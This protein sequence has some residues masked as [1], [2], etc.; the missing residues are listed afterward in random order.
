M[1][2]RSRKFRLG[3]FVAMMFIAESAFATD[4]SIHECLE[5]TESSLALNS[6]HQLLAERAALLV[7]AAE[8]CPT[9]IRKECLRRTEANN[10]AIPTI[11]FEYKDAA[12]QDLSDVRVTV[13]GKPLTETLTGTPL[14]VDPGAHVFQFLVPNQPVIERKFVLSTG[15]KNRRE[16]IRAVPPSGSVTAVETDSKPRSHGSSGLG[17]QRIAALITGGIGVAGVAVGSIF[18]GLAMSR[19]TKAEAACPESTCVNEADSKKWD[20]AYSAGNVSTFAFVAG[21]VGLAAGAILW[22][23]AGPNPRGKEAAQTFVGVGPGMV[24]LK[25]AF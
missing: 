17:S 13:D 14:E 15:Q 9:E 16:V 1:K 21:G 7:C 19:R 8:A 20:D 18:G 3:S 10:A 4:P 5:A 11:I 6:E 12:G 23:T 22:F 25:G 2:Q 24:Q